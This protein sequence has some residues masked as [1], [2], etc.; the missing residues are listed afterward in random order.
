[1]LRF[2][3]HAAS[4]APMREQALSDRVRRLVAHLGCT[5]GDFAARI[6]LDGSKLSR[7]L[8]GARRFTLSELA[9]IAEIGGVSTD[10]LLNGDGVGPGDTRPTEPPAGRSGPAEPGVAG[11]DPGDEAAARTQRRDEFLV[12]AWRLIAKH[13]YHAVRVADVA[14]ACGTSSAAVHYYFPTKQDVLNEALRFC[15]EQAFLRQ[16]AELRR[17]SDPRRRMLRLIDMQL[18]RA[19][20]VRDEWSIW[21]QFWAE[22]SLHAELRPLHN[23]FYARWRS[24]V[25]RVI[26]GGQRQGVFRTDI[27]VAESALRFTA[28]TDGVAIQLL[29]GAP[30]MTLERMRRVLVDYVVRE[31]DVHRGVEDDR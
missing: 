2:T 1:M 5:Q 19:G 12:A 25:M 7:S 17:V 3:Q 20:Q 24:A 30:D 10:W 21:L 18:P 28:L 23:E 16:G 31:L 14:S 9:R 6:G 4:L 8:N 22:A 11:R 29:T 26:A 13:G 27:D 15:V